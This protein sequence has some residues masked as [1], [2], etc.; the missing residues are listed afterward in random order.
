MLDLVI[1]GG[2]VVTSSSTVSADVGIVGEAVAAVGP[3]LS[4]RREIDA[5]GLLVF[6]GLVDAHTHM[7]LPVA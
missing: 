4:G 3:N 1:R 5:T 6:P 2:T 7:A